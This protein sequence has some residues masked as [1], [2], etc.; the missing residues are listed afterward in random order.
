MTVLS[1]PMYLDDDLDPIARAH[2]SA[3]EST[4]R[5]PYGSANKGAD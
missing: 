4:N 3:N 1:A 2:D 5:Q